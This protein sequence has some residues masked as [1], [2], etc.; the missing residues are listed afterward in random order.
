MVDQ[1]RGPAPLP[2]PSAWRRPPLGGWRLTVLCGVLVVPMALACG[3]ALVDSEPRVAAGLGAVAVVVGTIGVLARPRRPRRQVVGPV[4]VEVDGVQE[5]AVRFAVRPGTVLLGL[6]LVAGG[7][8][9]LAAVVAML[10]LVVTRGEARFLIGGVVVGVP[11]LV[12][13]LGGIAALS[14]KRT[15]N[16]VDLTPRH[17]LVETGHGRSDIPW[18]EIE[19][20]TAT[21]AVI[22]VGARAAVQNLIVIGVRQPSDLPDQVLV[23]CGRLV[24]DPVL[25]YH[26]LLYYVG[27]PG[28]RDE[29]ASDAAVRRLEAGQLV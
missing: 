18:A 13:L 2:W 26:G 3:V 10:V 27:R 9:L 5:R 11:G 14:S 7:V 22:P 15:N 6:G 29:L 17:V 23:P 24:N 21:S 19:S 25:V 1:D 8:A 20:V 12:L 28:D 4:T 16:A